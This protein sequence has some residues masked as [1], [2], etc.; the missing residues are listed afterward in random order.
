MVTINLKVSMCRDIAN[1]NIT[2]SYVF[3]PCDSCNTDVNTPL[4]AIHIHIY[5]DYVIYSTLTLYVYSQLASQSCLCSFLYN[6]YIISYLLVNLVIVQKVLAFTSGITTGLQKQGIDM[7][8]V[9]THV[10][11][12]ILTLQGV[13]SEVEGFHGECFTQACVLR[14]KFTDKMLQ[15]HLVD[16]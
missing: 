6:P 5:S 11:L 10:Q 14:D 7:V 13:Q 15:S 1:T 9:C 2:K 16:N 4:N 12:V 8:D 3:N